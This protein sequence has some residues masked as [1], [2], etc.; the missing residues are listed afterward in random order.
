MAN[1]FWMNVLCYDIW[2]VFRGSSPIHHRRTKNEANKKFKIYSLYAWGIPFMICFTIPFLQ[3]L[4]VRFYLERGFLVSIFSTSPA[5]ILVTFNTGI[6]INTTSIIYRHMK[7]MKSI[8]NSKDSSFSSSERKGLYL[9]FKFF[10]IMGVIQ[11]PQL[12]LSLFEDLEFV[13][14]MLVKVINA[15]QGIPVFIIFVCNKRILKGVHK[16]I[17]SKFESESSQLSTNLNRSS[18]LTQPS[19]TDL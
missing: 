18:V 13:R 2:L 1:I 19:S 17:F 3:I 6:F 11:I 4:E 12:V 5:F 8:Q 14:Q 7:E 9:Y 16:R 10:L 15:T